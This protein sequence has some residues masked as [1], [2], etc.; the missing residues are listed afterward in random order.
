M[1]VLGLDAAL[2]AGAA[3]VVEASFR[4][5]DVADI[6]VSFALVERPYARYHAFVKNI[7]AHAFARSTQTK[8]K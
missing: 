3:L 5:V 2:V 7:P 8:W 1:F 4:L 6:C